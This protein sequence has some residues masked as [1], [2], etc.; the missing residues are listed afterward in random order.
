MSLSPVSV[1]EPLENLLTGERSSQPSLSQLGL[2]LRIGMLKLKLDL[3]VD[4]SRVLII[5]SDA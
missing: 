5:V 1:Y 2:G 4:L 3:N